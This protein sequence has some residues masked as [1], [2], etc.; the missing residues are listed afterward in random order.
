MSKTLIEA[1]E[2]YALSA[3]ARPKVLFSKVGIVGCGT[4]GQNIARLVS[5]VGVE[6]VFV[7][8]D[9]EKISQS[10]QELD[11]SLENSI[12][13]WGMTASEKRA[14]LSRVKGTL[15]YNDLHDCDLVIEAIKSK[16]RE[17]CIPSR[18]GIFK[19]IEKHVRPDTVI[20][21][22]S[23]TLAITELASELQHKERC[24]SLHFLNMPSS[25]VVEVVRSLYTTDETYAKVCRFVHMLNKDVVP[26]E[27]SPG[28]ISVRLII[29]LINE[30]CEVLMESVGSME[31]IDLTLRHGMGLGLGPFEMADK[32]GLDKIVRWM[33]NLYDE[34]GD[35]RYKPSPVIKRLVRAQ[36]YGRATGKGFYEYTNNGKKIIKTDVTQANNCKK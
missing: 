32:I 10:M 12:A 14:I 34:F 15:D 21:T 36:H 29:T 16:S 8:I 25:R 33:D 6:V 31:D 5:G 28:L 18:K 19:N 9:Q 22:N 35:M 1:I 23:T 30:A 11:R 27:E 26:V 17:Y 7:E 24:V 2:P 13:R 3:K 4:V 20:A